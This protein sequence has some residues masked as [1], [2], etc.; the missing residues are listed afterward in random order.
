MYEIGGKIRKFR[1]LQHLSQKDLARR[2]NVKNTTISNWE[3]GLT[4]PDVDTLALICREL[5]VSANEMLDILLPVNDISD[6][7]RNVI[8][9]Y[10]AKN[11]VRIAVDCLLGLDASPDNVIET[12]F[13]PAVKIGDEEIDDPEIAAELAS[14]AEELKFKKSLDSGQSQSDNGNG[15]GA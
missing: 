14:Y 12:S 10:R 5:G 11:E 8:S 2:I 6:H 9:R 1:K 15:E 3:K 13:V 7:E 4:R